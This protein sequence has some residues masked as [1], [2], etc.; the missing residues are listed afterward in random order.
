[1]FYLHGFTIV[2]FVI[3]I[4]LLVIMVIIYYK[5]KIVQPLIKIMG[6]SLHTPDLDITRQLIIDYQTIIKASG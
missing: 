1:M 4:F 6:T 2:D 3:N 5:L